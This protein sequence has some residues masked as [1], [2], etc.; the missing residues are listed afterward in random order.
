MKYFSSTTSKFIYYE[1]E[2]MLILI[3]DNGYNDN[4]NWNNGND[5]Y[6]S[7]EYEFCTA[8]LYPGRGGGGRGTHSYM[9]I[10]ICVPYFWV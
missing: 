3:L 2:Q 6:S 1:S 7:N 9:G 10:L 5:G 4:D 8:L